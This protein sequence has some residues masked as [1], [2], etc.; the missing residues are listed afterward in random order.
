MSFQERQSIVSLISNVLIALLYAAFMAQRYPQAEPYSVE[1][2]RFWG[3]FFII[4]IPVAIVAKILV[5][6]LFAILNAIATRE[7]EPM[8]TDE[9]DQQFE[10]KATRRSLYVFAGGFLIAMFSLVVDTPPPAM[11]LILFCAGVVSEVVG[12]FSLFYL[13]RRGS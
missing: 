11:F 1:I 6:I 3:A 7:V 5:A 8:I 10:L 13:Y 4:L 12:D 2:F 9:R